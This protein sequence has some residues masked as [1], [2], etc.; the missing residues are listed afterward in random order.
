M[1]TTRNRRRYT[2]SQQMGVDQCTHKTKL[3]MLPL[4][5]TNGRGS[6]YTQHATADVTLGPNKWELVSVHT[7]RNS[8][9]YT[10]SQQMGV[11]Q[12][13]QHAT[14]GVTLG[15]N[16]W[17][18]VGVHTT[19]NSRC[20]IWSQQMGVGRCTHNTQQQTLH[21]VPTNGSGSVYTQ[22]ATAYVTLGPN[23]W[24]LVSVHTTRNSRCY[25]WC[26]QMGVG[27]CTRNSIRYTWS[28]QMGVG[29]CTHNTQQQ[30]LHLVPTNGSGSV[31]TQLATADVTLGRH[32]FFFVFPSDIYRQLC[33]TLTFYCFVMMLQV[34]CFV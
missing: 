7:T 5:P 28:Q 22:H 14:A 32:T 16:K 12:C 2:W 29:Q 11:G 23:K 27:Q 17:E 6:V 1:H 34:I 20:Y 8:R 30:M 15:P 33:L 3:Q 31:Y 19:R 4:V 24:E 10:W 21:L 9:C 25:T 26:Q 18:W 13:T